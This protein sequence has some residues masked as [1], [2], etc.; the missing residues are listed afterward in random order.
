[1]PTR[2][3]SRRVTRISGAITPA[4]DPAF[5]AFAAEVIR[6]GGHEPRPAVV[7]RLA[8]WLTTGRQIGS[9]PPC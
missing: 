3:L 1:M 6:F 5:R 8:R 2:S 9:D 4:I 7:D